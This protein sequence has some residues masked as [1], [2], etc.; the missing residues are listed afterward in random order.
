MSEKR[1]ITGSLYTR[2]PKRGRF[3][4][5]VVYGARVWV[6]SEKKYRH[7]TLKADTK[8]KAVSELRGIQ[9]DPESAIAWRERPIIPRLKFGDLAD[10]FLKGYKSR[11][12]TRHYETAAKS[13]K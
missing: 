8:K 7:F 4:G 6:P 13:W 5:Q 1:W 3:R 2:E 12:G 11:G 9:A 10:Q